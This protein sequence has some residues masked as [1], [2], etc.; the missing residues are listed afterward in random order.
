M[1]GT[2]GNRSDVGKRGD[3]WIVVQQGLLYVS[4]HELAHIEGLSIHI[5]VITG[6]SGRLAATS[7]PSQTERHHPTCAEGKV[8]ASDVV[9]A[10]TLPST[11]RTV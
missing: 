10:S 6:L 5:R 2:D 7:T 4:V 9:D 3:T 1:S 8:W 11:A